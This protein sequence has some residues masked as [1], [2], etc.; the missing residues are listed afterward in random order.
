MTE[1]MCSNG[2]PI[3]LGAGT[4]DPRPLLMTEDDAQEQPPATEAT[5]I[6]VIETG[7]FVQKKAN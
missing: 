6:V 3:R 7:A 1:H 5:P 4:S 2:L